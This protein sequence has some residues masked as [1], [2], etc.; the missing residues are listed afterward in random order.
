MKII[1]LIMLLTLSGC[2]LFTETKTE[3]VPTYAKVQCPKLTKL[4]PLEML[5]YEF[6]KSVDE[7]GYN[8]LGLR[9][10]EYSKASIN[11][12]RILDYI[13]NQKAHVDYYIGCIDRHNKIVEEKS[14]Q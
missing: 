8:T 2:S 1:L 13:K 10:D 7:E 6:V 14:R 3:Y 4:Q 12:G 11:N 9:G 5:D